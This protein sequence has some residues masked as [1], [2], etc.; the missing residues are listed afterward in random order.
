MSRYANKYGYWELNKFPGCNQ[1]VVSNHAFIYPKYRGKG[2]GTKNHELRL[3]RAKVLGYDYIMCT[4]ISTN[5]AELAILNKS[6]FKKL[7]EF[8]NTETGNTVYV[9]G[10][11][12]INKPVTTTNE[13]PKNK[14]CSCIK[15]HYGFTQI[16]VCTDCDG[17]KDD[18]YWKKLG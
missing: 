7:D 17:V 5:T 11:K 8:D 16:A 3:E 10:K 15:P 18:E 12:L 14:K 9:F 2:L 4:V 13:Q 6:G 1:I